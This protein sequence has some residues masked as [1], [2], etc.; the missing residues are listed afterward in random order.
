MAEFPTGTYFLKVED[1]VKT[2]R[3]EIVITDS[4]STLSS[5]AVSSVYKAGFSANNTSVAVR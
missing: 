4:A 3:H 2:V 5:K 1:N